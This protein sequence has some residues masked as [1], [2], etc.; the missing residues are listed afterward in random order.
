[1]DGLKLLSI[2]NEGVN[3]IRICGW[4][5]PKVCFFYRGIKGFTCKKWEHIITYIFECIDMY[6]LVGGLEHF[7]FSPIGMV[8]QSD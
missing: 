6:N 4:I 8:I 7:L 2:H 5:I 3:T 1:M